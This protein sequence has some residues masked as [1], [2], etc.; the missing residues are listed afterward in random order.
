MAGRRAR[1]DSGGATAIIDDEPGLPDEETPV[2]EWEP[3]AE[4]F[5]GPRK[6]PSRQPSASMAG[7]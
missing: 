6:L 4:R 5:K 7:G 2:P 3:E 1:A